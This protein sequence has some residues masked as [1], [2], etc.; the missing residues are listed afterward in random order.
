MSESDSGVK[1]ESPKS[2]PVQI[3]RAKITEI[4]NTDFFLQIIFPAGGFLPI[5]GPPDEIGV[6]Q[7]FKPGGT[8]FSP[9]Q[10]K[11]TNKNL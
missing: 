4:W 6:F 11:N 8:K 7:I 3:Q 5:R 9:I 1:L 2:D 10:V